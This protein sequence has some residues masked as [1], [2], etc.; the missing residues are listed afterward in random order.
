V[1]QNRRHRYESTNSAHMIIDKGTKKLQWRKDSLFKKCCCE[2]W[3]FAFRKLKV[4][5]CLSWCTSINSM[6]IKNLNIIPEILKLVQGRA[7]YT[8]ELIGISTDFLNRT[9]MAQKLKENVD[10]W[11]Y[12]RL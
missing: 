12:M 3:I 11:D 4:N 6:W 5:P 8:L 1:E 7:G 10:K 9:Q 2:N